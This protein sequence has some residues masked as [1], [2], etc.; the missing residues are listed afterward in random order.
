MDWEGAYLME[1]DEFGSRKKIQVSEDEL[2]F[3]EV[4][5]IEVKKPQGT[6]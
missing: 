4:N 5:G 3:M 1:V 2:Y 6:F